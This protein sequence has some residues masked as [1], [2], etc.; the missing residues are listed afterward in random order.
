MIAKES[1]ETPALFK[2][3][4]GAVMDFEVIEERQWRN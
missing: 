4:Q 3:N 2:K 1:R